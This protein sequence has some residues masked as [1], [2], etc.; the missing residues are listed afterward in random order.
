VIVQP[1]QKIHVIT[2]RLFDGDLRR[3]FVGQVEEA[4]ESSVR[5][6]GYA[7][8]FDEGVNEFRRRD[9]ERVRIFSLSDPGLIVNILPADA[10]VEE[11]R[12]EIDGHGNRMVTD[13]ITFS[14]NVS[15]FSARR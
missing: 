10:E 6:R 14:L 8:I 15:E 4:I 2:R 12:Y 7:F 5:V 13:G 3:H 11:I 1:G 9:D